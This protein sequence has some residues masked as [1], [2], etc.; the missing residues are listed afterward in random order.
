MLST[1]RQGDPLRGSP[2]RRDLR[3]RGLFIIGRLDCPVGGRPVGARP[4]AALPSAA[5]PASR[6]G[7]P[8]DRDLGRRCGRRRRRLRGRQDRGT[9]H[10]HRH[11]AR[12]GE[13][14]PDVHRLHGQV[15]DQ[16]PVRPA[17]WRQR[18]RDQG[19]DR[20][21]RHRP[22]AGHL[23]PHARRVALANL[24]K[25]AP[26][27]VAGWAD[28]PDANKEATGLWWNNYT[29]FQSIG[30]DASLGDITKVADLA[31]PKYK[32]KVALN[33][34]PLKAGSG[35]NGVVLAALANGGSADNIAPGVDFFKKL[36]ES[37]NLIPVDPAPAT[38]APGYD[39]DRDR[40][41]LQ[42]GSADRGPGAQGDDLEGRHPVRR[43]T[44]RRLLQLRDQQG[45]RAPGGR[46]L[47]DGVH[48]LAMPAGTP[49]SR[50]AP[51]RSAWPPCRRPAPS[52]RRPWPPSMH[53]PRP[54]SCSPL[55]RSKQP[56]STSR[57]TGSSSTSVA[58]EA[59][60]TERSR[61]IDRTPGSAPAQPAART[62]GPATR[63]GR[64]AV[65]SM[66]RATTSPSSRSSPTSGSSSSS[67]R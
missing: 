23:R 26:Y 17:G 42:R 29:G 53:R 47:L 7:R 1:H 12:L 57:T 38:I 39:A 27:K 13:L 55:P 59:R 52:T 33:G 60:S 64:L 5:R 35:F 43:A 46:A 44:C 63:R 37:G 6:Y 9:G 32:G 11:S 21:R 54:R 25:F 45:C 30:Y 61:M 51:C 62:T 19:G 34:D 16:G 66:G 14:R 65:A 28:I 41:D 22:P 4:S 8:Q 10:P 58:A 40:L 31:D 50:A 15:R 36:T 49:G 18:G 20:P 48:L 24:D 3:V 56:P 2:G 67:R